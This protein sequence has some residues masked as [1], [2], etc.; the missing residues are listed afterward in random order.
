MGWKKRSLKESARS[1]LWSSSHYHF[2]HAGYSSIW[3][4]IWPYWCYR[5]FSGALLA[6]GYLR[7]CRGWFRLLF[8]SLVWR[9]LFVS[10]VSS[11]LD[12]SLDTSDYTMRTWYQWLWCE[13][14]DVIFPA[15]SRR[16]QMMRCEGRSVGWCVCFDDVID[17]FL[18]KF[19]LIFCV[20][21]KGSTMVFS[22]NF[23]IFLAYVLGE[24]VDYLTFPLVLMPII[25]LFVLLFIRIPDSPSSLAKRGVYDVK[26]RSKQRNLLKSSCWFSKCLLCSI[27][28]YFIPIH[29]SAEWRRPKSHW[30]TFATWRN[31]QNSNIN[32]SA[33]SWGSFKRPTM[34][35]TTANSPLKTWVSWK[36]VNIPRRFS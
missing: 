29:R 13:N 1:V 3:L 17:M 2:L 25:V 9:L 16:Y 26:T 36:N 7:L 8:F 18:M 32:K 35:K 14:I 20:N 28:F 21:T 31:W 4:I 24:Y 11:L 19:N 34:A 10:S 5:D 6:V 33:K 22:C 23:G 12:S 27:L 30:F 15:T